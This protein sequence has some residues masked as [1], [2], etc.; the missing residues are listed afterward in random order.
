M[1]ATS[2]NDV[3][4]FNPAAPNIRAL[5]A[6]LRTMESEDARLQAC[7]AVRDELLFQQKQTKWL[8]SKLQEVMKEECQ[9]YRSNEQSQPDLDVDMKTEQ[10]QR[11]VDIAL[12][13]IRLSKQCLTLLMKIAQHW[14]IDKV[15]HYEWA[16][17][18]WKYCKMLSAAASRNPVWDE[19]L[20]K[21][22]Q[23]LLRR[24]AEKRSLGTSTNPIL[25]L[26]LKHLEAWPAKADFEVKGRKAVLECTPVTESDLPAGYAF[27]KFGLI[28]ALQPQTAAVECTSSDIAQAA[29]RSPG[30]YSRCWHFAQIVAL[31]WCVLLALLSW[32][33]KQGS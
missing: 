22:N 6:S 31:L 1:E 15:R 16:S 19:A 10:W 5:R 17:M 29:P 20:V 4:D 28:G 13:K 8:S 14:G 9:Q 27:D 11:F 21:L 32:W 30:R 23:L 2:S 18:G 3:F 26:D 12:S 24:I 25:R 7:I 33:Y